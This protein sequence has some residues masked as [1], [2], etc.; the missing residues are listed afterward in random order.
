M[1]K[2]KNKQTKTKKILPSFQAYP[3]SLVLLQPVRVVVLHATAP[4]D[5]AVSSQ[6]LRPPGVPPLHPTRPGPP[7]S[8][9]GCSA[10]AH[11]Q[12]AAALSL[13]VKKEKIE[14]F[15]NFEEEKKPKPEKGGNMA[16]EEH[17]KDKGL[18]V[19]EVEEKGG[20]GAEGGKGGSGPA[21][22]PPAA[23]RLTSSVRAEVKLLHNPKRPDLSNA[24][25]NLLSGRTTAGVPLPTLLK[26][27]PNHRRVSV[28]VKNDKVA[29]ASVAVTL[30]AGGSGP[31][32]TAD[33]A[34][35]AGNSVGG[36]NL[37]LAVRKDLMPASVSSP[38]PAPGP[39]Q[40][41]QPGED[42]NAHPWR[43]EFIVSQ[44]VKRAILNARINLR[45]RERREA[46]RIAPVAPPDRARP[47]PQHGGQAEPG[48]A[49]HHQRG[50]LQPPAAQSSRGESS[51]AERKKLNEKVR[52]LLDSSESEGDDIEAETLGQCGNRRR[53]EQKTL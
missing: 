4:G 18:Q 21:A 48:R 43:N 20:D 22:K 5:P 34:K 13:N 33:P 50:Q 44:H 7:G 30:A 17:V 10:D 28:I 52:A 27:R 19:A 12:A 11:R 26:E 25:I 42:V 51:A 6:S 46:L 32:A 45:N 29:N 9:A 15:E 35:P 39:V 1:P 8:L 14:Y 41:V 24:K 3:V 36:G 38:A 40:P 16:E 2:T 53:G 23:P 37:Q 47:A 49:R 31:A